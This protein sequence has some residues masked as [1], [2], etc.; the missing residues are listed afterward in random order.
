[1]TRA[2]L[3]SRLPALALAAG[4]L[5]AATPAAAQ[6]ANPPT[7]ESSDQPANRRTTTYFDFS[8]GAGYSSNPLL[9][10]RSQSSAFARLSLQA[11]HSWN[12]ERGST[13]LSGYVEDTTYVKGSYG[14]KVIFRVN[15]H[16][17]QALSEKVRV[18][19]D[20]TA[21]GDIAGQ[22]TN[23]FTP[24]PI[25][26]PP[27]ETN[28]PP[29]TNLEL[30][31]LAGR[32]YRVG[33]QVGASIAAGERSSVS[34]SAGVN[35]GFFTG[36]NTVADYTT[37]EAGLGWQHK[38]S[39]R[40]SAGVSVNLQRQDFQGS[41]YANVVNTMVNLNTQLAQDIQA[42][43]S[44]GILAIYEHRGGQN[45]HSYSPSFSGSVC[46]SGERSSF[47]ARV[48]RDAQAPLG[49][50]IAQGARSASIN[51]TF[52][53]SYR[54]RVGE[55]STLYASA[56]GTRN[57]TV[58]RL[59]NGRFQSTYLSGLVGYDHKIGNRLFAG[60]TVGARR[61]YQTGPDPKMDFN[62]NFYLRYRL[63]DLL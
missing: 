44:V 18:Y 4:Y 25:V 53:L 51:T 6:A 26:L 49:I 5:A 60:V 50:G 28:P 24:D 3:S 45:D 56:N 21:S 40:T 59:Q 7:G 30:F 17:D 55:F 46:K 10:L 1:M 16:T 34:L 39:E 29:P 48:S 9:Q 36:S 62:G 14:S 35:H 57:S 12:S 43:G 22:L 11:F 2:F 31:N 32:Q 47:C 19:G 58:E 54:R 52:D 23:R 61:L 38:L 41:D 20:V 13:W 63:G 42:S 8:A 27:P 37:Y 33:A 15:A